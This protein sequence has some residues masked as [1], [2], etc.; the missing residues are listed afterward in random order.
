MSHCKTEV[1]QGRI[2]HAL[3]GVWALQSY[4]DL[5]EGLPPHYPFGNNPDGLLIYTSDGFVSAVLMAR[6]R[7]NLGGNGFTDG[8][9]DQYASAGKGFIGYTGKYEMDEAQSIVTH[10]PL[11]AFAPNMVGSMQQRRVELEG[12][13]LV[14]IAEHAHSTDLPATKSRLEWARV[15]GRPDREGPMTEAEVLK[16]HTIC[17]YEALK[18]QDF[19]ALEGLYS[20]RYLLVRPDG[21]ILNKQ[22]VLEDLRVQGLTFQSIDLEKEQ[23]RLFGSVAILTGESR[24]VST[25]GSIS[26]H[27]HFRFAAVYSQDDAGIRLVHFQSTGLPD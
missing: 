8:T 13:V 5:I 24:T 3:I 17:F 22:Q 2:A 4:S 16:V 9:A 18:S 26:S 10:R 6:D 1:Q 19:E 27:A 15:S 11:A 21:S 23:V 14:L 25:R 12:D 20:D 7:P